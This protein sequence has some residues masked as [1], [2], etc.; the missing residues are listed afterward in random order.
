[1]VRDCLLGWRCVCVPECGEMY[2]EGLKQGKVGPFSCSLK[3]LPMREQ[4]GAEI[5]R[6]LDRWGS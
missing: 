1:M 6:E 5:Q 3:E 4:G 2:T